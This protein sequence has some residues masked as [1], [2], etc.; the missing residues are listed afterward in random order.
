MK[1]K[2][3]ILIELLAKRMDKVRLGILIRGISDIDPLKVAIALSALTKK[4]LYVAAVGYGEFGEGE[5]LSIT[6]SDKIEKAVFWR[7]NPDFAGNIL[8]FVGSDSEKLHSLS[9][10]D[11]ISTR[12]LSSF[13]IEQCSKEETNVP[14]ICFWQALHRTASYHSFDAIYEFVSSVTEAK[15]NNAIPQNMWRLGLLCDYDILSTN[16]KAVD[17]LN[18]NRELITAI[19]QLSEESRKKLSR[20]LAHAKKD[21]KAI[22]QEAY[23]NLQSFFK[24]GRKVTLQQLSFEI[25]QK[26]FAASKANTKALPDHNGKDGASLVEKEP[27]AIKPK[28]LETIISE[29]IVNPT[30]EELEDLKE[31]LNELKRHFDVDTDENT[32][33][34]PTIGGVFEDRSI[35]IDNHNTPLRKLVGIACNNEA[36]G[37][38][39]QTEETVFR[40]AISADIKTFAAFHPEGHDDKTSFDGSSLFEVIARFDGQFIEKKIETTELFMPIVE[41]LVASRRYLIE[42][43]DLIMY[44]PVLTFGVDNQL[45]K[46]L[47]DYIEAWTALLRVYC[48]NELAM[49]E[50]S[51]KGSN[52]VARALLLLDVLYVKTPKEWKGMLMPLHPLYLWRYYEVFKGLTNNRDRMSEED[53]KDLAQVISSLPQMVNFLV[54]DKMISND[55]GTELPCSGS[56]EMLPTFENKTNR[57]LGYDGTEAVE[58]VLSRWVG[59]APYTKTEVRIGTV[60]APDLPNI[61]KSLKSF[62]EKN[63]CERIVYDAYLTR[64][65]NGNSELAKL[66]YMLRDYEVGEFIKNGKIDISIKNV[67]SAYEVKEEL[68]KKPVH[69]A[70]YFDQA[71]YSIE[72][73]PSTKNLYISPLVITYDY[74][75][76]D[77]THRGEIFPSSDMESGMIGDYH[78]VMRYADVVSAN[79]NPRPTYNPAAD[80]SGVVS[81][82]EDGETQWL[83]VADRTT[84]NYLPNNTIPIGEKQYG[85]RMVSIW[86]SKDSRII[87]QYLSL[88]RQYNLYP[89]RDVLVDI[90]TQF[91]HI[92]SEGLISIPRFG[93]DTQAIEN[94]KKGLIGTIF[95]AAWYRKQ[96]ENS[97]VASLDSPDAKLWLY[98]SRFGNERADLIGL[99]FNEMENTLYLQPIEVKTRDESPD[100]KITVDE[101]TG[102]RQ[103]TGHAAD[104]IAAVVSMLKEIFGLIDGETLNMFVSARREVLKYQIVSECFRHIHDSEWQKQWSQ[105]FKK[106]FGNGKNDSI[107][108]NVSGMLLHIKLSEAS[109]GKRQS[110]VHPAFDDCPIEFVELTTKEIQAD[111]IGGEIPA[112]QTWS[113]VDFDDTMDNT[114]LEIELDNEGYDEI[115]KNKNGDSSSAVS[116]VN[117]VEQTNIAVDDKYLYSMGEKKTDETVTESVVIQKVSPEEIEQLAK[118]FSRSCTDYRINLKECDP[119]KAVVGPSIIR[120]YFKLARGQSLQALESNLEDIGREMKRSGILVQNIMN[121]DEIILDVP[122]LQREQVLYTEVMKKLPP[123]TSPEKLFFPVGRTPEGRDLIKDLGEMPHMLIGGSTGSGKTVFLFTLLASLLKTHPTE[124]ELQLVLSSSGLEDFIHFEGLPHLVGGHVISDAH[125]ATEVIK[126]VVFI[127][128]ERREKVLADARVANIIQYNQKFQEKLA[129]MVVVIDEFADLAD[130]LEKKK[131]KDAF[132]TPV[133]RIAQIGRKRGIHL[134]LCTQRPAANLVPSNIKSQLNGR[135]ALRVNDA[136][137]SRMILEE[138]GAQH[139]QKHGDLIYKNI[140]EVERAQGY[141]ISIEELTNIITEIKNNY[142]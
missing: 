136:N 35:A 22:L 80:I 7:S 38:I 23:K 29:K 4:G 32:D 140:S 99:H 121:S 112:K 1:T 42:S 76:D 48:N 17:R 82:I 90:L 116:Y 127:E 58:E 96:Y 43:I 77:I 134:V 10:F 78:K 106:A 60:D 102:E 85:R 86:S 46:S 45:K 104:Q 55:I 70:F 122:R 65:Q 95:A 28:E 53:A 72:Y 128:F 59:F 21:E 75:F 33:E 117:V 141:F 83:I 93:T 73:G 81:T 57:Y 109:G 100:A 19:G 62:I 52:F 8:T 98:D 67:A 40:D 105:V 126:N 108:I 26:L 3:D 47:V 94:R 137:S 139:L 103:I 69:L 135:L 123:V 114:E 5:K 74:E 110:C 41:K 24:Y 14:T 30:E 89:D 133:K 64:S 56:I 131:D 61:L 138:M 25:V 16:I 49:H 87:R 118:D 54:V 79:R 36:W 20:S 50:I 125:E 92:S 31:L 129:P 88:L 124:K 37:G 13:L 97:L 27:S 107:K 101:N 9:E 44:Y 84:S 15:N 66:D 68:R 142:Q 63:G 6:Y 111:I 51:Q 11:V 71:A 39:L 132:F 119:K 2:E 130:Q 12:D 34:I 91:G 18:K 115:D 120:L 113:K